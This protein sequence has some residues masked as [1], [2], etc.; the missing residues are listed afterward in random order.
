MEFTDIK[1]IDALIKTGMSNIDSGE[2]YMI[3][4][5]KLNVL[6][7]IANKLTDGIA[8]SEQIKKQW[9]DEIRTI[10]E[11]TVGAPVNTGSELENLKLNPIEESEVE[12]DYR[13]TNLET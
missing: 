5:E 9:A 12:K 2:N 1:S 8:D 11:N 7:D 10:I 4:G 13:S 6:A 3:T